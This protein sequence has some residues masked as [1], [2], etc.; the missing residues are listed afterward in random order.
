MPRRPSRALVT[1]DC[2]CLN[3]H[4]FTGEKCVLNFRIP[5]RLWG[6]ESRPWTMT[7]R[8]RIDFPGLP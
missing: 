1:T 6:I 3:Q 2:Y 5:P 7:D 4:L 8:G